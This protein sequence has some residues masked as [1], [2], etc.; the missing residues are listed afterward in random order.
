MNDSR[1]VNEADENAATKKLQFLVREK[2]ANGV[3]GYIHFHYQT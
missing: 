3:S 1:V 2:L